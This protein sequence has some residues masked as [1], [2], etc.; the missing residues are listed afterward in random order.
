MPQLIKS[1]SEL[2]SPDEGYASPEH[3][4]AMES[5]RTALAA[6]SRG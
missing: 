1:L 4:V 6:G 3:K 2:I 5:L